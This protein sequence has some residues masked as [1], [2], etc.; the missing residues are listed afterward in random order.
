MNEQTPR[1]S[2]AWLV[3]F[4]VLVVIIWVLID[5]WS[6]SGV[7]VSVHFTDGHGLAPGDRVRCRGIEVGIVERV[8]LE[9]EGVEVWIVLDPEAAGRLA[10]VDSRWWIS[11]PQ[12]DWSRVSG[13][14]SLVGPRFVLVDPAS[15][16]TPVAHDFDGLPEAPIIEHFAEG[17][18]SLS[19]FAEDRGTLHAGSAVLYRGVRI[20]TIHMTSL[21]QDATGVEVKALVEAKYAP[22]VRI[23][24]KFFQT[25]ALD[26][27]IGLTGLRARLDSLETLFVGGVTLVTPTEPGERAESGAHFNVS[28]SPRDD[29]IQWKPKIDLE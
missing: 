26:L 9:D 3:P 11:R 19:L 14:D 4:A 2:A 28:E 20:G 23:N 5:A 6:G 13:L 25:G 1:V 24:S 10:R 27:D 16:D 18:L 7:K 8:L 29:W 17:D 22:L 12:I 21:S 15:G